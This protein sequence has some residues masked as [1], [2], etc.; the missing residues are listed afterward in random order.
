MIGRERRWELGAHY[1]HEAD[2]LKIIGPT[3]VR[4]WQQGIDTV[5]TPVAA[6]EL[7]DELTSFVVLD[8]ACTS[9]TGAN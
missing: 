3:I 2:I 7:L 5:T 4:P 9:S 8:P 6:R 1:T